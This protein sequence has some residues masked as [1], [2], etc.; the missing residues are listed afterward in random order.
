MSFHLQIGQNF[1]YN[2]KISG[3]KLVHAVKSKVGQEPQEYS[4][5]QLSGKPFIYRGNTPTFYQRIDFVV[6]GCVFLRLAGNQREL[7]FLSGVLLSDQTFHAK[8]YDQT[9]EKNLMIDSSA[10]FWEFLTHYYPNSK[11]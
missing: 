11:V 10:R 1:L 7:P 9:T 2:P 5:S 3:Y 4:R 8:R 6:V